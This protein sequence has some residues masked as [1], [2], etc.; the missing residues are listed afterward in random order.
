MGRSQPVNDGKVFCLHFNERVNA[1]QAATKFDT[2]SAEC[3]GCGGKGR[4]DP[5]HRCQTT[6]A[7]SGS[8]NGNRRIPIRAS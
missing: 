1:G 4:Q 5:R 8:T 6:L 2:N 3:F 7:Q